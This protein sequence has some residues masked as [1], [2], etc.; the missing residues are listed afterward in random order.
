MHRTIPIIFTCIVF[1][2]CKQKKVEETKPEVNDSSYA[3]ARADSLSKADTHYLWEPA[4]DKK[5]KKMVMRKVRPI[6][7]DS[8][9]KENLIAVL[10][11]EYADIKVRFVKISGDTIFIKAGGGAYL[12]KQM[13]SSGSEIYMAEV[14]YNL[15][16]LPNINYVHFDFKPGDH[17]IPGT[18]SRTDFFL[19]E[20]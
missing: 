6:P 12:S 9:T 19:Q 15:T 7:V 14:T 16:E 20:E 11:D 3:T 10:N 17:A 13:G 8:L 1:L 4:F 5:T 18:Y 2:A